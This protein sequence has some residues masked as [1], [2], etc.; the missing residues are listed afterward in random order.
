MEQTTYHFNQV[1]IHFSI[2]S[3]FRRNT[4][5]S[6]EIKKK[7]TIHRFNEVGIYFSI[8]E[9]DFFT[10]PVGIGKAKTLAILIILIIFTIPFAILARRHPFIFASVLFCFALDFIRIFFVQIF[11]NVRLVRTVIIGSIIFLIPFFYERM[12]LFFS[13]S[14][15]PV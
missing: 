7:Q 3:F 13:K 12:P 1:V 2:I 14:F 4:D 10:I 15:P 11:G 9:I 6:S 5:R 8:T